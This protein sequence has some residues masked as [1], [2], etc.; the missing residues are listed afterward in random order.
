MNANASEADDLSQDSDLWKY[1]RDILEKILAE[2]FLYE[3]YCPQPIDENLDEL[4]Q[5]YASHFTFLIGYTGSGKTTSVR[6]SMGLSS[7]G[8]NCR[9]EKDSL[10]FH[11]YISFNESSQLIVDSI[12]VQLLQICQVTSTNVN[13]ILD[14]AET[15]KNLIASTI[16]SNFL[17]FG[18]YILR[19]FSLQWENAD[20]F[21]YLEDTGRTKFFTEEEL[22]CDAQKAITSFAER[23]SYAYCILR[24]KYI[25]RCAKIKSITLAF[26]NIEPLDNCVNALVRVIG[27]IFR[28]HCD[29]EARAS[30]SKSWP[31]NIVF[32]V[33]CRPISYDTVVRERSLDIIQ[34]I[35]DKIWHHGPPIGP[36]LEQRFNYLIENPD[37]DVA[38]IIQR[39]TWERE[40]PALQKCLEPI[41][42]K[43]GEF[44]LNC[45]NRDLRSC[46][47]G[48]RK[49]LKNRRYFQRGAMPKPF[50]V[51]D[52]VL[53]KEYSFSDANVIKALTLTSNAY[54]GGANTYITNIYENSVDI[55]ED[56]LLPYLIKYGVSR[57][58]QVIDLRKVFKVEDVK[59]CFLK[60][61]WPIFADRA[62]IAA[63]RL[64]ELGLLSVV[65]CNKEVYYCVTPKAD[66]IWKYLS[67][68]SLLVS[69]Y[70]D[71]CYIEHPGERMRITSF[72]EFGEDQ[73]YSFFD[74]IEY[75]A[76]REKALLLRIPKDAS[77]KGMYRGLFSPTLTQSLFEGVANSITPIFKGLNIDSPQSITARKSELLALCGELERLAK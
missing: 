19:Y 32:I 6:H 70:R 41:I 11:G 68:N 60:L 15:V 36:V 49:I 27:S 43:H 64:V 26:D 54:S 63:A 47:A 61:N 18:N 65:K 12:P 77:T 23:N 45:A 25:A 16:A 71:D 35:P 9:V 30:T 69:L 24:F 39:R 2:P 3:L 57:S 34:C 62:S 58:Y 42:T 72:L 38:A 73:V 31:T 5:P 44:L 22:K 76:C 4:M 37:Q 33:S 74:F 46:F 14:A 13:D 29:T 66:A 28:C 53:A 1:F 51:I 21:K 10:R 75:F 7:M 67:E 48:I 20:F 8:S 52:Q 59:T 17:L 50:V 56:L 55:E 40:R